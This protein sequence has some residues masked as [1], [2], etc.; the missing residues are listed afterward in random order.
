MTSERQTLANRRNAKL[1]AGPKTAEGKHRSAQNAISHGLLSRETLLEGEDPE[2][3][4][5][6][7]EQLLRELQPEGELE[8]YLAGRIIGGDC[9][10]GPD[11]RSACK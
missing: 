6:V 8:T 2:V 3:F 10:A 11:N 1:S 5:D 4:A 9:L 7:W